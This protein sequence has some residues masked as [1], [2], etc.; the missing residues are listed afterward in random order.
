MKK[1]AATEADGAALR[2]FHPS[3]P[4]K[5]YREGRPSHAE[6]PSLSSCLNIQCHGPGNS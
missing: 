2:D 5:K 6:Y 1:T 4:L 3:I